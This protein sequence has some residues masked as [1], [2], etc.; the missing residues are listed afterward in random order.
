MKD[1]V[2]LDTHGEPVQAGRTYW[3]DV[4]GAPVTVQQRG[5][6]L[7]VTPPGINRVPVEVSA[8]LAGTLAPYEQ[9]V[10]A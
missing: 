4:W 2:K 8:R 3:W 6:K 1:A 9:K 7:Y 5:S 10:G